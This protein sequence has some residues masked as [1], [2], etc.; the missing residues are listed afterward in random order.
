MASTNDRDPVPKPNQ[1]NNPGQVPDETTVRAWARL[2]RVSQAVLAAVEAD[3]KRA[4]FPPLAHYDA[5]L[6]LRRAGRKGLRP[7]ELQQRML[8]AQYNVS[9]LVD[10][11]VAAGLVERR[12][13]DGDGRGQTLRITPAGRTTLKR[14]WPAYSEA[15]AR[16][17]GVN[18]RPGEADQLVNLLSRIKPR[19]M[20]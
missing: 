17:F 7:F 8:L 4:G 20:G 18:L 12:H 1:L 11:L 10:R 6:E 5:L 9:R 16:H 14:M 19:D 13:L 15:I 3:V 2:M